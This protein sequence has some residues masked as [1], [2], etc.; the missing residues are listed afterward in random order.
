[1]NDI[2]TK[3]YGSQDLCKYLYYDVGDPLSQPDIADTK[4]LYDDKQNQRII[5]TPFNLAIVNNEFTTLTINVNESQLDMRTVFYNDIDIE[6]F[7]ICSYRNWNLTSNSGESK[8]RPNA[9][10]SE[11]MTLFSRETT[12]GVGSNYKGKLNK[13]FPNQQVGGYRLTFRGMDFVTN[14]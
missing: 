10:I 3:I 6:F 9:I 2:L 12:V 8:L 4:I 11:L 13:L 5:D 14:K 1:M 7:V